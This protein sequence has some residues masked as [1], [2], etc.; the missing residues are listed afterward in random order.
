MSTR[1]KYTVKNKT[2]K[3]FKPGKKWLTVIDKAKT[4][5]NDSNVYSHIL[6]EKII[7]KSVFRARQLFDY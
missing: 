3:H 6:R 7:N 4:K 2:N 1:R 5:L